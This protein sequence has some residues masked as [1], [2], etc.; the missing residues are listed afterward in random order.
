M[1][2]F[3]DRLRELRKEKEMSL[4]EL[5]K[6]TGLTRQALSNY[7]SGY[8]VPKRESM[9]ILTDYFNVDTDWMLGRAETR[10]SLNFD[11]IYKAGWEDALK[12]YQTTFKKVPVYSGI[13]CGSGAWIDENPEAYI[14]VPDV[15]ATNEASCYFSNPAEGD[16]M[17]PKIHDGDYVVFEKSPSIES[18][19]IGA[20]SLNGEFYCKRFRRTP[21]GNIWLFSDNPKYDP[22]HVGKEDS[23]HVLGQYKLRITKF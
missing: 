9:E 18:G 22:I 3:G 21:D 23:F 6:A 2:V 12:V 20:F 17:E 13:S 10:N 15:M 8:R 19:Q 16:S 4:T 5:A 11:G 7:E 1:T 14:G